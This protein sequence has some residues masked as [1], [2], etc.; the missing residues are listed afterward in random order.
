MTIEIG[1]MFGGGQGMY[2]GLAHPFGEHKIA[3]SFPEPKVSLI[4][5][6]NDEQV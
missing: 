3:S 4:N 5:N 2:G 1:R 6:F